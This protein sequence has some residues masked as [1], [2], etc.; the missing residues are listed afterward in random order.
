MSDV[1]APERA[2]TAKTSKAVKA[3]HQEAQVRP[4][5]A[6]S[7]EQRQQMVREAAYYRALARGFA[8]GFEEQDWLAAEAELSSQ[9]AS[10]R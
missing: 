10:K 3:V 7:L 8:E 1:V 4:G 2:K 9:S 6:V 5:L